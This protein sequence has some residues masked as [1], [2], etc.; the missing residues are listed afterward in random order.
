MMSDAEPNAAGLN[1]FGWDGYS[2]SSGE[3]AKNGEIDGGSSWISKFLPGA[4]AQDTDVEINVAVAVNKGDSVPS[5]DLL[6]ISRR[7]PPKR[8]SPPTTTC[9]IPPTPGT[10]ASHSDWRSGRRT[11]RLRRS[12]A[13]VA[14][15]EHLVA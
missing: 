14:E 12:R 8:T 2:V 13:G 1:P 7:S 3:M 15:G 4:F 5:K 6:R 11:R 9:S 10:S